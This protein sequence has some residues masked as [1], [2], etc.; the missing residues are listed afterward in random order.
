MR[1][2]SSYNGS[3]KDWETFEREIMFGRPG[4]KSARVLDLSPDQKVSRL[5][6]RIWQENGSYWIEDLNSG[7]GTLLNSVEIKG[8][9]KRMIQVGDVIVV[10]NTTIQVENL[11][12]PAPVTAQTNFLETGTNLQPDEPR[13]RTSVDIIKEL[14]A[15][16]FNPLGREG[17]EQLVLSA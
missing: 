1:I 9:G 2:V 6:G 13:A 5:H 15:T 14:D 10:G 4:E 12:P 11:D 7:R 16:A 3:Q 8:Q 17:A